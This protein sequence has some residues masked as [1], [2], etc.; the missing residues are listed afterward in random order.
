MCWVIESVSSRKPV[1]S[2]EFPGRR[3]GNGCL[4]RPLTFPN[5]RFGILT[6]LHLHELQVT[7]GTALRA[8][9][10]ECAGPPAL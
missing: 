9:V 2:R 7:D 8:S 4:P 5:R 3:F 10:L 1:R 6:P